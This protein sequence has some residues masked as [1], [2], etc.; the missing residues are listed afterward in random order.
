MWESDNMKSGKRV[1]IMCQLVEQLPGGEQTRTG[2]NTARYIYL[3]KNKTE[4]KV[5][6][7]RSGMK[8]VEFTD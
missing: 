1:M 6:I 3:K 4:T 8:A 2:D 5:L 7:I